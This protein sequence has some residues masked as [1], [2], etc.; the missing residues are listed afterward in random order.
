MDPDDAVGD[1][2]VAAAA[3][4]LP[5]PFEDGDLPQP[6]DVGDTAP[7]AA[8]ADKPST[9]A[10]DRLAPERAAGV[11]TAG[12]PFHVPPANGDFALAAAAAAE[13][14]PALEVLP[15][16]PKGL[17]DAVHVD[18]LPFLEDR[19]WRHKSRQQ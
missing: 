1:F 10:R 13:R 7:S 18:G 8:A 2:P 15:L 3:A 12:L 16:E 9:S 17:E 14:A 19:N 4:G 5:F 11:A 6:D